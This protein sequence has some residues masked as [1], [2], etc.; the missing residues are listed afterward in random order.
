MATQALK[1]IHMCS[2]ESEPRTMSVPPTFGR[3]GQRKRQRMASSVE[4]GYERMF[5]PEDR[6]LED[7][8]AIREA[9]VLWIGAA[10]LLVHLNRGHSN[11]ASMTLQSKKIIATATGFYV[12]MERDLM[13][14]GLTPKEILGQSNLQDLKAYLWP[15]I[16][17]KDYQ[18]FLRNIQIRPGRPDPITRRYATGSSH[19]RSPGM[20]DEL[21]MVAVNRAEV[22]ESTV[23]WAQKT[24]WPQSQ[25]TLIAEDSRAMYLFRRLTITE[26]D[27]RSLG[28]LSAFRGP[29]IP[30]SLGQ[31]P[32][33][34]NSVWPVTGGMMSV[35]VR[36]PG[37][38]GATPSSSSTHTYAQGATH[39]QRATV[40]I[41][42]DEYKKRCEKSVKS[43]ES[44][45]TELET[46]VANAVDHLVKQVNEASDRWN[47]LNT[48]VSTLQTTVQQMQINRTTYREGMNRELKEIK[49]TC[50]L[51]DEKQDREH[52]KCKIAV[53]RLEDGG[54]QVQ[55]RVRNDVNLNRKRLDTL[56]GKIDPPLIDIDTELGDACVKEIKKTIRV[57]K[58]DLKEKRSQAAIEPASDP[59]M[60]FLDEAARE[61]GLAPT[62]EPAPDAPAQ[63]VEELEEGEYAEYTEAEDEPEIHRPVEDEDDDLDEHEPAKA[64]TYSPTPEE[65]P[66]DGTPNGPGS[67][68]Q[69]SVASAVLNSLSQLRN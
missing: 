10:R 29:W 67:E 58:K 11:M 26:T 18:E 53:K 63:L 69:T 32:G 66:L 39:G 22:L 23:N 16:K 56:E 20:E 46:S 3:G 59:D 30:G 35:A 5:D 40:K 41:P 48:T 43:H 12:G 47:T 45:L 7:A 49:E 50:A 33:P 62:P 44:R 9:M 31:E 54:T 36:R 61:M 14:L 19:A 57:V 38:A 17:A 55:R 34:E 68:A 51:N 27:I 2:V 21:V 52:G 6:A 15:K 60:D 1:S 42:I 65:D 24:L 25:D 13:L 4:R 64:G 8:R 28:V 37:G